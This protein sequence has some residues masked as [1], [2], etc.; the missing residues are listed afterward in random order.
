MIRSMSSEGVL[1][2][3]QAT[4]GIGDAGAQAVPTAG[5]AKAVDAAMQSRERFIRRREMQV[6]DG[7]RRIALMESMIAEFDRV[8]A[9]LDRDILIEQQRSGIH[10]P[11]HFAYPTYAKAAMLR[12]DNLKRSADELR[13]KL[14]ETKEALRRVGVAA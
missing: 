13:A 7:S 4:E 2:P 5:Q 8:A 11:A 14:A 3:I 12:R 9:E 1:E 6:D 10:D